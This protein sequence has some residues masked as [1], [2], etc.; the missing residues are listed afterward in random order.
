[1]PGPEKTI[2]NEFV[3]HV[4]GFNAFALKLAIISGSGFPDRTVFVRGGHIAFYEFKA[5]GK[6]ARPLQ[7]FWHNRLRTFGFK[8]EVFDDSEKAIKNFDRW[9]ESLE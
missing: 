2:E 1:M 9:R 4:H 3:R 5:P 7:T 6:K 8:V